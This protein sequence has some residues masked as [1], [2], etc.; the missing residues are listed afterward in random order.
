MSRCGRIGI[1]ALYSGESNAVACRT[2]NAT[3]QTIIANAHEKC[4]SQALPCSIEEFLVA[5]N[6]LPRSVVVEHNGEAVAPFRVLPAPAPRRRPVGDC[7]DRRRRLS[8]LCVRHSHEHAPRPPTPAPRQRHPC[9]Y[10]GPDAPIQS[11]FSHCR[12]DLPFAPHPR[13][14]QVLRARGPARRARGQRRGDGHGR[15]AARR[16]ERQ[17]GPLRQHPGVH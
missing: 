16:F 11:A 10:I 2:P 9:D 12:A 7:E 6:L 4:R 1:M 5:Q 8:A 17:E 15:F 13:H 14:G 3:T